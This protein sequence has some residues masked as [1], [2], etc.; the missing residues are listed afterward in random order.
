MYKCGFAR[1]QAPYEAAF[2]ELYSCLDRCEQI[3][4]QRRYIAGD[5]FTEADIRLYVT[6]IRFDEV[7]VVYFKT[8]R[9]CIREYPN[10]HNFVKEIY[11]M[12]GAD[13]RRR[14]GSLIARREDSPGHPVSD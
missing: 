8:N 10:L 5:Q 1:A 3:L 12:P 9:R 11:Q 14:R 7:Y 13:G 6:L 2:A 4:S